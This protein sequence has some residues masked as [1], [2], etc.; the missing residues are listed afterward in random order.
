MAIGTNDF[1]QGI[2]ERAAFVA[3]YESFVR[4]LLRDHPR[5]RIVLTEGAILN[6]EKKVALTTYIAQ[7]VGLVGDARVS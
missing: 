1:T 5:S 2:P 4:T 6:G 7:T 3:A